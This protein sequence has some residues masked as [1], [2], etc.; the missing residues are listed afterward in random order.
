MGSL[1]F[2]PQNHQGDLKTANCS[3]EIPFSHPQFFSLTPQRELL[4]QRKVEEYQSYVEIAIDVFRER[5][6]SLLNSLKDF[7]ICLPSPA[8][9]EAV[10]AIAVYH[11]AEIDPLICRWILQN[12]DYL[13]PEL[14]VVALA[15]QVAESKLE[16]YGFIPERDFDFG[17]P[18][19][20]YICDPAKAAL[21]ADRNCAGDRLLLEEILQIEFSNQT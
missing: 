10:L 17:T 9:I 5:N 20:P 19:Q 8:A 14:D 18:G 13:M 1:V 16:A 15:V 6:L 2:N 3:I 4:T 12:P 11:L 21:I 7:L